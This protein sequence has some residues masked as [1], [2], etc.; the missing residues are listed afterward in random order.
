MQQGDVGGTVRIVF[1]VCNLGGHAILVPTTEVDET[2]LAL[3]ATTAMTGS[4]AAVGVAT[5]GLGQFA[6][7]RLLRR[8]ARDLGEVRDG[9]VA[10]ACS[11]RLIY[12]DSHNVVL[13]LTFLG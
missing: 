3:V 6:N 13:P 4:H 12:A 2:V 1:D 9:R 8:G 11:R 5:T 10:A 7:Q